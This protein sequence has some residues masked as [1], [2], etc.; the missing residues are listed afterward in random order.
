MGDNEVALIGVFVDSTT[1]HISYFIESMQIGDPYWGTNR[2]PLLRA[3]IGD[4]E[5][6]LIGGQIGCLY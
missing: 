3:L 1:T 5:V 4:N 2:L 6:A